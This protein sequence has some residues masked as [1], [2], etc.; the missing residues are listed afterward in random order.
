MFVVLNSNA[1]MSERLDV[2]LA[3]IFAEPMN[4]DEPLAPERKV[5]GKNVLWSLPKSTWVLNPNSITID[6]SR[7]SVRNTLSCFCNDVL[8]E[9]KDLSIVTMVTTEPT[10]KWWETYGD[11]YRESIPL[12]TPIRDDEGYQKFMEWY[13]KRW[14]DGLGI[15]HS[16]WENLQSFLES[17][18]TFKWIIPSDDKDREIVVT[19]YDRFKSIT[20]DDGSQIDLSLKDEIVPLINEMVKVK[21]NYLVNGLI[22]LVNKGGK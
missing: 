4:D 12:M 19:W 1:D 5:V 2:I 7:T 11:H 16:N 3:D 21:Y 18:R 6:G 13:G 20:T 22:N 9:F 15:P 14:V 8:Q 17:T 10:W